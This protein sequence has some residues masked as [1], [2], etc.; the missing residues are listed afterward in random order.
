MKSVTTDGCELVPD[1]R[2][3]TVVHHLRNPLWNPAELQEVVERWLPFR[4]QTDAARE[5]RSWP[6]Y[7]PTKLIGLPGLAAEAD[8]ARV[9]IKDEGPRFGLGSFKALGGAYAVSALVRPASS[10]TASSLTQTFACVTDGN[11][12]RAVA[13]G[14]QRMRCRSVIYLHERV[15][16]GRE[17][18]LR[19]LGAE[20]VRVTGTY[21]DSVRQCAL[22]AAREGWTLVGDTSDDERDPSPLLVMAGYTVMVEEIVAQL[23]SNAAPTHIFCRPEWELSPRPWLHVLAGDGC[24]PSLGL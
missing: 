24:P 18:A 15:S 8:V 1:L 12:G 9:W 2:K 7:E 5:I 19:A 13:W 22:D 3:N 16:G 11:H 10:I 14:A 21:D 20:I 4:A 6:A 17:T 23:A